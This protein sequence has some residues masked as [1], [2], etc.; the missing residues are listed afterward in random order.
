VKMAIQAV[1]SRQRMVEAMMLRLP[2]AVLNSVEAACEVFGI[3]SAFAQ[4]CPQARFCYRTAALVP[5][6]FRV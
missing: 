3:W 6:W 1:L 2:G 4:I 5:S